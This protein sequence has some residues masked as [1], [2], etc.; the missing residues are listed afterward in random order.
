MCLCAVFRRSSHVRPPLDD[1]DILFDLLFPQ[2]FSSLFA[3]VR[4]TITG[5]MEKSEMLFRATGTS[6]REKQNCRN[7]RSNRTVLIYVRFCRKM[8]NIQYFMFCLSWRY[9]LALTGVRRQETSGNALWTPRSWLYACNA[10][11]TR[12][13]ARP[14]KRTFLT[15]MNFLSIAPTNLKREECWWSLHLIGYQF[16]Q[17]LL[18]V[19]W[20]REKNRTQC[21]RWSRGGNGM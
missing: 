1:N 16:V 11:L 8:L 12:L 17:Y 5:N 4:Q 6:E 2:Y 21:L 13:L 10:V 3:L 18:H 9:H 15:H 14:S 19:L 7:W 20:S